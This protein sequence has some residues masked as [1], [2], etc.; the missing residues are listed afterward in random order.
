MTQ[1]VEKAGRD[2]R[3]RSI[4][5][6]FGQNGIPVGHGLFRLEIRIWFDPAVP[7]GLPKGCV[8]L[9]SVETADSGVRR[10]VGCE[11]SAG[12]NP[13]LRG[14]RRSNRSSATPPMA[15]AG[16]FRPGPGGRSTRS[17]RSGRARILR[18][19]TG[20]ARLESGR[21]GWCSCFVACLAL[22]DAPC[23]NPSFVLS[24]SES[25]HEGF[26]RQATSDAIG[27]NTPLG[28]F[29]SE[30]QAGPIVNGSRSSNAAQ[31]A[32]DCRFF[33]NVSVHQRKSRRNVLLNVP[34]RWRS[35]GNRQDQLDVAPAASDF[36]ASSS[37]SPPSPSSPS[38][39]PLRVAS[40]ER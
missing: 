16:R 19:R 12:G 9:G 3:N 11:Q 37:P 13:G 24:C 34:P 21:E 20:W 22:P 29:R 33:M 6:G 28:R 26:V 15:S 7:I 30:A 10:G 35:K 17:P 31:S 25:R 8:Y 39:P 32:D 1:L 4:W 18:R 5:T 2:S 36:G 14:P 27:E 23:L 38:S 40:K